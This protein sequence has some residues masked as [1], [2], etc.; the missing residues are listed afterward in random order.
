MLS[1]M[2]AW[3]YVIA[4]SFFF[5]SLEPVQFLHMLRRHA[6]TSINGQ[7]RQRKITSKLLVG[8]AKQTRRMSWRLAQMRYCSWCLN[9]NREW[10]SWSSYDRRE[11]HRVV[12]KWFRVDVNCN[13][14]F[15]QSWQRDTIFLKWVVLP[16]RK[17]GF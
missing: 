14:T 5:F 6:S 3:L 13:A 2:T 9:A 15:E 10:T 17:C 11:R 16:F 8:A 4:A 12:M 7:R 1:E